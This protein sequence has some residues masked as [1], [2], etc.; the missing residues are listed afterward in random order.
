MQHVLEIK[1]G[2][3]K[4]DAVGKSQLGLHTPYIFYYAYQAY[5]HVEAHSTHHSARGCSNFGHPLGIVEDLLET[6][7]LH[8][9]W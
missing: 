1:N 5:R 4:L 2:A 6:F 7:Q 8:V 9:L 3:T